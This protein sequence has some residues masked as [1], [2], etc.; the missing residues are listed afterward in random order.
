[1]LRS[2]MITKS[3]DLCLC[4]FGGVG[5]TISYTDSYEYA[6]T[7]L[8]S[9]TTT[10]VYGAGL[11]AELAFTVAGAGPAFAFEIGYEQEEETSNAKETDKTVARTRSF[12]LG[13]P[14]YGDYFDVQVCLN[15]NS[16]SQGF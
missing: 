5:A 14:D 11:A 10:A 2:S 9:W 16:F 6:T 12:S 13:D 4:S 15:A 1:M 8:N 7:D 3:T